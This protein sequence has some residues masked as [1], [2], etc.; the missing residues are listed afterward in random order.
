MVRYAVI[1]AGGKGTR[2]G[3]NTPKQF[4]LLSGKPI[5]MHTLLSFKQYSS[6]L[7]LIVVL[8]EVEIPTWK[9]LC[10]KHNFSIP[11]QITA[12]GDSRSAS[13]QKGLAC[14]DRSEPS[15]VAI[16]DGVRPFVTS[17]LIQTCFDSAGKYGSGVPVVQVKD[18]VRRLK[19]GK[20]FAENRSQLCLVQTPQVF[21]TQEIWD[22]YQKQEAQTDDATLYELSGKDVTLV[23]GLYTNIKITTTDDL[24]FARA[25][26]ASPNYQK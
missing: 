17:S 4:I 19:Q 25:I 15:L 2:M 1:V 8:P 26:M 24:I 16:H 20:N 21:K 3:T 13:V 7:N 6:S 12:G 11:H 14:I 5:L 18:S 22:A 10:K 9:S 23:D